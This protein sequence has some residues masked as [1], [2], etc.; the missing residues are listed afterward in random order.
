MNT[1]RRLCLA[2][3]SLMLCVVLIF[4]VAACDDTPE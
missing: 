4:G 3:V 2:L 1:K